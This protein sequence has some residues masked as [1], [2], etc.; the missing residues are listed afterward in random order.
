MTAEERPGNHHLADR[1]QGQDPPERTALDPGSDSQHQERKRGE[2]F[3]PERHF[4]VVDGLNARPDVPERERLSSPRSLDFDSRK[5]IAHH[6]AQV[7]PEQGE[8][9]ETSA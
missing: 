9:E 6:Q 5:W 2:A 8:P 7:T 4:R 1:N 3:A